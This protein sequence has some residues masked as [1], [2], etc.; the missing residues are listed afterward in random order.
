MDGIFPQITWLVWEIYVPAVLSIAEILVPFKSLSILRF[1]Q[2]SESPPQD[3]FFE[4]TALCG[5]ATLFLSGTLTTNIWEEALDFWNPETGI[6]TF[7]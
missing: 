4:G 1:L 6:L 7:S 3:L 2:L 5:N